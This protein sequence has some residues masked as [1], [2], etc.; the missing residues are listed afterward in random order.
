VQGCLAV[1][2]AIPA[3]LLCLGCGPAPEPAAAPSERLHV[4]VFLVDTLRADALGFG[5]YDRDTSPRLDAWAAR[6]VVFD[7]ATTPA[8][9]P[10]LPRVSRA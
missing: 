10:G 7:E 9:R 2:A 8:A 4:F 3:C 1:A 5:G 6:G